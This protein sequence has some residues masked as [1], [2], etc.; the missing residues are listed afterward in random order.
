MTAKPQK[1]VAGPRR[2]NAEVLAV[3][4]GADALTVRSVANGKVTEVV[5]SVEESVS[6]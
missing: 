4:R 6:Q 2:M 5:F 1:T 3:N